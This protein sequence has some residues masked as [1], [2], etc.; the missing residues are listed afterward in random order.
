MQNPALKQL[1]NYVCDVEPSIRI[2]AK[3]CVCCRIQHQNSCKIMCVLQSLALEQL[4][5]YVCTVESSIRTAAKL[6]VY[7]RVQHQNNCN[8]MYPRNTICFRCIILN[9]LYKFN[10]INFDDGV[11]HTD[12]VCLPFFDSQKFV[13][14]LFKCIH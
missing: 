5:N 12:T 4:Q 13:F 3:L 14:F 2:A 9:T 8:I 6:C 7:C 11:K 1:Q 10:T